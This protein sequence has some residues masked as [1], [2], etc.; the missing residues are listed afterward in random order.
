MPKKLKTEC[1]EFYCKVLEIKKLA[2]PID[3]D[4]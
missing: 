3:E 2:K 4:D 1:N